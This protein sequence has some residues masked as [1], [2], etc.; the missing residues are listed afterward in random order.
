MKSML[1][2]EGCATLAEVAGMCPDVKHP[3]QSSRREVRVDG[4]LGK[5]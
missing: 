5:G 2:V 3:L 4:M 1:E